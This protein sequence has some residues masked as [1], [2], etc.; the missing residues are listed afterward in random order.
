LPP[1]QVGTDRPGYLGTKS[2]EGLRADTPGAGRVAHFAN[3]GSAL[4]PAAVVN[5]QIDHLRLEREIGGYEAAAR[6]QTKRTLHSGA[7]RLLGCG[8]DEIAFA[9]SA[10]RAW[11]MFVDS[12]ALRP[13]D[14]ILTSR[15]EFGANLV[16]L[17]RLAART[18]A[19]VRVVRCRPDGTIDV[20]ALAESLTG[21]T[22]LVAI[23][24][25]AAHFGGV[26]PAEQIGRVVA[27]TDA[28]FLV[29]AC[30]S[31]GQ[32]P[33]DVGAMSC[34]ALTATGRK[35]LR[36]PRGTGFL[37]VRNGIGAR[38][39]RAGAR[40][41]ELWERNVA[42]EIGLAVALDYLREIGVDAAHRRITGLAAHIVER[43]RPIARTS[44]LRTDD[45]R[46]G[47][48]GLSLPGGARAVA[49]VKDHL[50]KRGVNVSAMAYADAPLDCAARKI[51]S[52]LRIAPHYYNTEDEV[53]ELCAHL[54]DGLR[55]I[56]AS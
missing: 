31:L 25:A 7:A 26:N 15:I 48:I 27:A 24:Q 6:N 4:P 53:D 55:T 32:L 3:C 45:V 10:S 35:W 22:K 56:Q 49:A 28:L 50:H 43:L 11:C 1:E 29:D 39:D 34:H 2:I 38:I 41:F 54:A 18:G 16:A 17:H 37:Y 20:D 52:V 42:A 40:R 21:R 30:Q 14:E 46:S 36:G 33:V 9:E 19:A 47:V 44:L 51:D 12:L 23:T 13:G 8:A 5:A